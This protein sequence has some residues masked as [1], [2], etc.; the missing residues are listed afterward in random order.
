MRSS[1]LPALATVKIVP[2]GLSTDAVLAGAAA[3]A[4]NEIEAL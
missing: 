4:L 3:L 1:P 2:A